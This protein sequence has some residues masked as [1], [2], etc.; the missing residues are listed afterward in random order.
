MTVY[1]ADFLRD[2]ATR[3]GPEYSAF[4]QSLEET[5]PVSIRLHPKKA[6]AFASGVERVPW[7]QTGYY[8]QERP[9]FTLDPL[10]HAGAYYVQ[11]ASS[12]LLEPALAAIGPSDRP[13]AAL[14]LCAAPGGKAVHLL[15]LLADG[16]L[17][18]A[19]E[20]HPGRYRI[21][22]ENMIRQG[23]AGYA[24]TRQAP[25]AL[26]KAWPE[27]FDLVLTDAPCSGEGMFRKDPGAIREWSSAQVDQCV[28]RQADILDHAFRLLAPGGFLVYSTCTL[29]TRENEDQMSRLLAR[30]PLEE[31]AISLPPEWGL[32][33]VSPG[34]RAW[35]HRVRGEGFYLCVL[36]KNESHE[37][38]SRDSRFQRK[39]SRPRLP[40]LPFWSRNYLVAPDS[41][42]YH[43]RK[44]GRQFI[45]PR[46]LTTHFMD[47]AGHPLIVRQGLEAG[48]WRK[49]T[50]FQPAHDLA[51]SVD[52]SPDVPALDLTLEEA[53]AY[54]RRD[55]LPPREGV[56]GFCL[57]RYLN[58]GLGWVKGIPGRINNLYPTHWRIRMSEPSSS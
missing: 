32:Q 25:H 30:Y 52:L 28:L 57:A 21:L 1:P 5:P 45:F 33:S 48:L 50:L 27:R 31:V 35:P 2:M 56:A 4:L 17:L 7:C 14:D 9:V 47:L 20:I 37:R 23:R 12:M 15:H 41:F 40:D 38:M 44:D 13:R 49:G 8:L 53:L 43:T 19:N 39:D 11:E 34:I 16:D 54:L 18:V 26:A 24:L 6:S 55:G 10:F 29:N 51:L 42:E 58:S 36:R 46:R 22:E 3:L